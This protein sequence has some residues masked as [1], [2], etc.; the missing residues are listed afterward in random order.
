[1]HPQLTVD[2]DNDGHFEV[3]GRQPG[4]YIVGVGLLA[5]FASAEWKSRVDYPGVPAREQA[6]VI[7]IGDGEWRT[8]IDFK[9]LPGSTAP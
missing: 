6:K 5:P 7:E 2:T 9:L 3:G 4:Q 8:D 1:V